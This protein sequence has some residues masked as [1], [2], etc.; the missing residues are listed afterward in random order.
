MLRNAD[1]PAGPGDQAGERGR[2]RRKKNTIPHKESGDGGKKKETKR[3]RE[4]SKKDKWLKFY[5]EKQSE[6]DDIAKSDWA[7]H[8]LLVLGLSRTHG[9][10]PSPGGP[11]EI[12]LNNL[13]ADLSKDNLGP[14]GVDLTQEDIIGATV[15]EASPGEKIPIT[16][17][18]LASRHVKSDMRRA[19]ELP[20][21]K[22]WGAGTHPVFL[23]DISQD[24]RNRRSEDRYVPKKGKIVET[25]KRGGEKKST[26]LDIPM[27][28]PPDPRDEELARS[29]AQRQ[30]DNVQRQKHKD[31]LIDKIRVKQLEKRMSKME[32]Q[33]YQSGEDQPRLNVSQIAK[34]TAVN[35]NWT[36]DNPK[37]R[38]RTD[39]SDTEV[40]V[41]TVAGV[42]E[43]TE[44]ASESDPELLRGEEYD[45]DHELEPA[46]ESSEHED[47][48][49][50]ET[51]ED[52]PSPERDVA[53]TPEK[54]ISKNA[55][56]NARRRQNQRIYR[57]QEHYEETKK[58]I[59][60]E[61]RIGRHKKNPHLR[62]DP[63]I[64]NQRRPPTSSTE[65][66]SDSDARAG[67]RPDGSQKTKKRRR[68]SQESV[69]EIDS[70]GR[71][72]PRAT[73]KYQRN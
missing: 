4:S 71:K 17:I 45:E 53:F 22:R 9:K 67:R 27:R 5:H 18:T 31:D 70:Q 65:I 68:E 58:R 57:D 16:R 24:Q 11:Q 29:A 39:E 10:R 13:M 47:E 8:Q 50:L 52:S 38:V 28:T 72:M 64:N 21:S 3:K 30:T 25:P 60:F 6:E 44:T 20:N 51:R 56:K 7:S 33:S 12:Q 61:R 2:D 42:D 43:E 36:R 62:L 63:A 40:C 55:R 23:R 35:E 73:N 15:L 32:H 46:F 34:F 48:D 37:K 19:A 14:E 1:P 59:G 41:G 66:L 69:E 49:K 54:P 26:R